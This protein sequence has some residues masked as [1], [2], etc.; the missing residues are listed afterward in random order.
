MRKSIGVEEGVGGTVGKGRDRWVQ[1]FGFVATSRKHDHSS[2]DHH[3]SI[4]ISGSY[5]QTQESRACSMQCCADK[6][7]SSLRSHW[8][9]E[10]VM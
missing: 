5:L 10:K 2:W 7:E 1:G 8:D 9:P 6:L 4:E 3:Y